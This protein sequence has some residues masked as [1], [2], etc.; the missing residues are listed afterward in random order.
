MIFVFPNTN[1]AERALTDAG[2]G[3]SPTQRN[4]PRGLIWD[5][6]VVVAKWRNLTEAHR[7]DLDGVM[8]RRGRGPDA[9]VEVTLMPQCPR[10]GRIALREA[11][12]R[13]RS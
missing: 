7:R 12:D 2:F 10:E 9:P 11:H 8:E 4:E 5:R 3:T 13:E 1:A 6:D